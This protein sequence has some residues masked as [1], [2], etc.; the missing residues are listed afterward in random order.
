MLNAAEITAL[1]SGNGHHF[2]IVASRYN[3]RLVDGMLEAAV[4][5]LREA[6]APAPEI[7]R[8]PGA[9]E[10]PVVA[11]IVARRP[12]AVPSAIICLGLILQGETSHAQ[13]IGDAVS[14][15]LMRISVKTGV[16][17][18]H[19][20][21]TVDT[22]AQAEAR[23]LEPRANRGAEAARTALEMAHLIAKISARS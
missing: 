17:V 4:A 13:H 14:S 7:A 23:C 6:G 3:T 5:T 20:V 9:W 11:A 10:I 19:E 18:I 22:E 12:L 21:L 2:V 15:A 8:V 16:P 1:P